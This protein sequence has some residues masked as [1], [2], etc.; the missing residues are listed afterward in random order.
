MEFGMEEAST[1]TVGKRAVSEDTELPSK[2]KIRV[3]FVIDQ[4]IAPGGAERM[5]LKTIRGLPVDQFEC[6]LLTFKHDPTIEILRRPPCPLHVLPLRKTYDANAFR[7]AFQIRRLIRERKIDIAHT[8]HET[9]DLFG[10]FIAKLGGCPILISSRRDMG[11]L[12]ST[13][14]RIAYRLMHRLFDRVVS[15]SEQVRRRCIEADGLEPANVLTVYNGIDLAN[16][17]QTPADAGFRSSLGIPEG[18]RLVTAVSNIR[19]VKAIDILLRAAQRVCKDLPQTVFL[20]IGKVIE[21]HYFDELQDLVTS[22]G[23]SS[24]VRFTNSRE[25]VLSIL[26]VSSAF[27][28]PS[29]SEGFSNALIE[30]MACAL[31]CVVTDVGGNREA[32]VHGVNG[33]LVQPEDPQAIADHILEILTFPTLG[34]ELG[35]AARKT[36]EQSFTFE[37]MMARLIETYEQI[38]GA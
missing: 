35:C 5:L 6:H 33:Y 2:R 9:S 18:V 21:R 32:I 24:H 37:M 12:R 23:L 19:R 20:I 8:F 15:V 4:L 30:A 3:L 22:L 26:K 38:A 31:P 29:R 10:G 14:H 1:R 25:D 13:K 16:V 36:V 34:S 17:D 7:V 11:F 27:C 28:L